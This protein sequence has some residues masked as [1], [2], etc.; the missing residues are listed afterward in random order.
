MA[1]SL[2]STTLTGAVSNSAS[3]LPVVS[4]TGIS[5]P[6]NNIRQQVYVINPETTKGELMEVLGVSGLQIQVS[7]N[8]L[9]RQG[10]ISGA[11]V[12]IGRSPTAMSQ[13]FGSFFET[14]PVGAVTAAQV[15]VVPYINVTNG[16]QW[17]R[18][19]DGLWIPGFNNPAPNKGLSATV[20]S[21]AGLNVPTGPL[22]HMSGTNA[23]TGWTLPVG[24]SGGSFSIIPDGAFTWTVATNIL[25]AGTAVLSRLVT[26]TWDSVAGKWVPSYV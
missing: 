5:A 3:Y 23:V 4:A 18:S 13:G 16:N 8:S 2:T 24:F 12:V 21:G 10:F 26:F 1:Y 11:Y 7:R 22:F 20:A 25:L 14:D 9:F 19:V 15:D 6:V 17:L